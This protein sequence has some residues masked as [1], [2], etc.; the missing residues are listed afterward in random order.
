MILLTGAT[1]L[2]GK[3]V[4]QALVAKGARVRALVRDIEKAEDL[5]VMG[6]ELVQG[7]L[8]DAASLTKA[9]D[10]AEKAFLLMA[11]V[12]EQLA[13]EKRFIDAAKAAGVKQLV[14]LSAIEADAGHSNLLKQ[15][16]GGAEDHL[17]AS[18]VDYT[19]LRGN[20][21]MQYM[22][23]FKPVIDATGAFYVPRDDAKMAM[24]DV[25]DIADVAATVLTEPGHL[26]K[27]YTL[28]GSQ[29][30]TFGDV[31][32]AFSQVLG[33]DAGCVQISA[34]AYKDALMNTGQND[35]TATAVTEEFVL[36][37]DGG[38]DVVT[39]DIKAITGN[40]PRTFKQMITEALG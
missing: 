25:R 27:I 34:E 18:G 35:W 26:G 20:V 1:G 38:A 36:M 10:G 19:I 16:H 37:G 3:H 8:S 31:A 39:G 40:E 4:A 11:N 14:K 5:A 28:T 12:E 21:F 15:Y 9:F 2:T 7:D 30:L 13:C 22:L 29:V 6:I 33:K 24:V 23:Y 17:I 32:A